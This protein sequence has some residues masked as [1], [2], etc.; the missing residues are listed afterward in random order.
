MDSSKNG[1]KPFAGWDRCPRAFG[2]D[3]QPTLAPEKT[4]K[5]KE[6]RA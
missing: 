1:E 4:E 3:M 6:K 5:G 2:Q